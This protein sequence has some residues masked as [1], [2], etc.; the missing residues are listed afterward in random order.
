MFDALSLDRRPH[1]P[2]MQ[3]VQLVSIVALAVAAGTALLLWLLGNRF[4][5]GY[6][7][8]YAARPGLLWMFRAVDDRELE[9][10]R[11]SALV[12]LPFLIAAAAI[13]VVTGA[14]S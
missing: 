1:N 7:A 11:R 9:G 14:P 5:R 2:L 10:T 8:R 13:Y 12:T 4:A 6:A 3:P